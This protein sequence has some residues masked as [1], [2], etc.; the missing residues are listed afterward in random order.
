M[1][2]ATVI[3][4]SAGAAVVAVFVVAILVIDAGRRDVIADG[5]RIGAVDVGG[6]DR[7]RA[8]ALV[9]RKLGGA[10]ADPVAVT[11]GKRRFVLHPEGIGVRLDADASVTAALRRS[12]TGDPFSRVLAGK[13][14]RGTVAPRVAFSRSELAAFAGRVAGRVDRRAH[15]ADIDWR[16]GKLR[17]THA[18]NG[19]EVRRPQLAAALAAVL[20][21]PAGRRTTEVPVMIT[22]RPDRTL[23]DLVR[24]YP[25]VIAVDRDGKVLRLYKDL[26]LEQRYKIAVGKAGL[27]TAAGRYKIQEKIV[28]PPWHVPT[29][30]WAGALAGRTIAPNDPQNPLEA[31]WM[32]FHDGQGIHGT[33]DIA[34]LGTAASHGCIR[35][36]VPAVKELYSKVK[37]GTP[38]FLQ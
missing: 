19:I 22:Q 25:T 30:S 21:D 34:S 9:Q 23:T 6:L 15:D 13:E 7:G 33:D 8:R 4:I 27:E 12:R 11:Y 31:R 38:V 32:G 36:A 26:R 5:V 20:A 3:G 24:R 1:S 28:N 17:R 16:N 37:V 29:S 10:V 18:R 14:G 35:M 2:R